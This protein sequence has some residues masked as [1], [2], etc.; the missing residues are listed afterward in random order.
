M[1]TIEPHQL[2]TVWTTI[3]QRFIETG[4]T[5]PKVAGTGQ[6]RKG[7]HCGHVDHSITQ[8]E[9]SIPGTV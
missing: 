5:T 6:F 9:E 1:L 7:L 8:L 3:L 4:P 2:L